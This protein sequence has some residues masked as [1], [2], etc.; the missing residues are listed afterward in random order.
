MAT[1][2]LPNPFSSSL[3]QRFLT[4]VTPAPPLDAEAGS[5]KRPSN[6]LYDVDDAPPL[7][8]RLGISL[9]HIFLMSLGWLYIVVIV[10]SFGGGK[11]EAESLIRM[12]MIAGGLATILQ[13]NRVLIGSGYFCPLSGSLT[14]LQ[15]SILAARTAGLSVLFGLVATAGLFTS[16]LSRITSRLRVLFPP[17]VTGLMVGMSGLQLIALAFPRFVGSTSPASPPEPQQI[18]VGAITLFAMVAA[19]VWNRGKLHVLPILVGLVVGYGL[20]IALGVLPW[21]K[22]T[23]EFNGP[24]ISFPHRL[25]VGI[26]FRLSLLVPF[27]IAS[28]TAS[29]K[30]VGDITLCQKINDADWKRTDMQSVSGGLFANGVGTFFSGLLGGVAQN[31]VSSSIGLSLATGATSRKIALPT[32]LIVVALAFFPRF[33]AIFSTMPMPV[34]GAMLIYSACFIVLG[35]F[36]LLTSRM[37]DSR[38]IFA[39]GI[40]LIFGLSVEISPEVY[41]FA[42]DALAPIFA[43]SISLATIL[44]VVLSLLFRLGVSKE[45]SIVFHPGKETFDTIHNLMEE[46]GAAWGMRREVEQRAE[47]A[48]H[49]VIS[50]VMSLN[51]FLRQMDITLEFDELKLSAAVEYAGVGPVLA[52]TA[53]TPEQLATDEGI[54]AL[55]G[56]MIRGYADRV[57][58]KSKGNTSCRIQLQFD[59]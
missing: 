14:F 17:E 2:G 9:Q 47:H 6:L 13:A 28:L 25:P 42:P 44:V 30:T 51:P 43:S 4:L 18:A 33:T 49:E 45:R 50:S 21:Q 57:R 27:L 38:R 32:G 34:M 19:T 52:E 59:H 55:S 37:L 1:E 48:I 7:L 39:V 29:L 58:V 3:R 5:R 56:F 46:Q 23:G 11:A 35:G 31:T 15:P 8:V 12:S 22:F 54:A 16:F 40:S 41:R 36:Q 20:A 10:N 26:G 53:P 24:W